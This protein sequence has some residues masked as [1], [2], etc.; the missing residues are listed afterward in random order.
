MHEEVTE[1]RSPRAPIV[2]AVA[3]AALI[4]T[5]AAFGVGPWPGVA[6]TVVGPSGHVRYTASRSD[7]STTVRALRV[8]AAPAVLGRTTIDG[9]WG[10]PAV[11][12]T[13]LAGGLSPDGRLLV[14]T[15]PPTYSGLR[16]TSTFLVL[17][18]KRL[19][20]AQE[21][22]VDGEFGFDTVSSDNRTLYLIQ[23]QSSS[24]LVSYVVRGYDLRQHRLLKRAIVA[25]GEGTTMR[26]YPVSRATS[27]RGVWVYT[28]YHRMNGKPF[29]HALNTARRYAICIDLTWQPPADVW[30]TRLALS[31]DGRKLM[32][33]SQGSVVATVNTRTFRVT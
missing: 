16:T 33:R 10:I 24:D 14:L 5:G 7:G 6:G 9:D 4:A 20:I 13:G 18:T 30:S 21:V 28:L 2:A 17:S 23:H 19:A 8:G 32:V 15:Q 31:R 27:T 26:G 11:T 1:M 22:A 3:A 25:K 29:V 12:S